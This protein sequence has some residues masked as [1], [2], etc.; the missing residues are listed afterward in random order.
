MIRTDWE[1]L[2]EISPILPDS[3]ITEFR[4]LYK[5]RTVSKPDEIHGIEPIR[6]F[7]TR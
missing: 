6:I 2:T 7:N 1:R 4:N 5:K 3:L